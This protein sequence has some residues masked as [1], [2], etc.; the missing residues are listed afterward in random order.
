MKKSKR[1]HYVP[2]FIAKNFSKENGKLLVYDKKA[3]KVF[4][5]KPKN[6]FL[7]SDRNTF[8]NYKNEKDDVIE[9]I[10]ADLDSQLSRAL[11]EV[12]KTGNLS[13]ENLKKLLFLA[14][15]TKWRVPE[16]DESFNDAKNYFTIGDLGLG[17]KIDSNKLNIYLESIFTTE[18]HQEIKRFLLA[19]QP[20]RFKEDYKKILENSF[21][22]CT[23]YPGVIGDCP[24]NEIPVQSDE[25]FE[26]F[27]FPIT[28]DLTLIH[29]H[30]IDKKK[31][32]HFLE[33]GNTESVDLFLRNLS[34]ARDLSTVALS[35]RFS[36][37]SDKKYF[38]LIIEGYKS[39][40]K[41]KKTKDTLSSS[42]FTILYEYKN[43]L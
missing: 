27:I 14:Y 15:I 37:C 42:V 6:I 16:Y 10:Y 28:K 25:I 32:Q 26:D 7:E 17:V 23:P 33:N 31:F 2:I 43:Y 38:D 24:V 30:R 9:K 22:I 1:H 3:D 5:A 20:F 13:G 21:L 12:K 34:I 39:G 40:S 36:G 4:E 19:I 8:Y 18:L 35:G 11:N 41:N 29:S